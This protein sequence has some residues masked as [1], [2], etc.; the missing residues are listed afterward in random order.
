MV[1]KYAV[2]G[3]GSQLVGGAPAGSFGAIQIITDP[4]AF[5]ASLPDVSFRSAERTRFVAGSVVDFVPDVMV[6]RSHPPSALQ[7]LSDPELVAGRPRLA[8]APSGKTMVVWAETN[9]T[10]ED[11]VAGA[12]SS[13]DGRFRAEQVLAPLHDHGAGD[14]RVGVDA[15]GAAVVVWV[16]M[17]SPGKTGD[18]FF[19]VATANRNG[20]IGSPQ[21]LFRAERL[22]TPSVAVSPGG[23]AVATW[24]EDSGATSPVLSA[25]RPAVRKTFRLA[26]AITP[27]GAS[28]ESP[29]LTASASVATAVWVGHSHEGYSVETSHRSVK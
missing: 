1:E 26:G 12:F 13:S 4:S 7:A 17:P 29:A 15:R 28:G 22:V 23:A 25:I 14:P 16:E 11:H 5:L 24:V 21:D 10:T 9:F 27:A 20:E 3:I 2:D 18:D 6:G 8:T 19:R